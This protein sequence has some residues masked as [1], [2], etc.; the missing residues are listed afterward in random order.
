MMITTTQ[1]S[2]AILL[3]SLV[4]GEDLIRIK[5]KLH[6]NV[7][8]SKMQENQIVLLRI[9]TGVKLLEISM[10]IRPCGNVQTEILKGTIK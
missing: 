1:F 2:K 4:Q 3:K 6:K 9:V 10:I 8:L 5:L 7:L